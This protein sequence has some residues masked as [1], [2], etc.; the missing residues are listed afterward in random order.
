MRVICAHCASEG[1]APDD[2]GRRV[3]CWELLL[4]MMGEAEW[5]ELLFADI[6]ALVI[7]KR[8]HV[9]LQAPRRRPPIT[10]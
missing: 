9:L 1:S 8:V 7:F 3:S 4:R 2:D 10:K 5:R 6:S